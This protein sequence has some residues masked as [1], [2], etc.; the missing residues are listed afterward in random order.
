VR[1]TSVSKKKKETELQPRY[2]IIGRR[3]IHTDIV[4]AHTIRPSQVRLRAIRASNYEVAA[5]S[6]EI[7]VVQ[8]REHVQRG[9][10]GMERCRDCTADRVSAGIGILN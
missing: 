4:H 10:K 5:V 6:S 3:K 1:C 2:A 8:Q 7:E 9:N